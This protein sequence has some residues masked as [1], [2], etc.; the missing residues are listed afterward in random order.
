MRG[1]TPRRQPS[2]A[3]STPNAKDRS[4]DLIQESQDP[5]Q[6]GPEFL[7][8]PQRDTVSASAPYRHRLF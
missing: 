1:L 6:T 8:E 3:F 7:G 5:R 2:S 4:Y